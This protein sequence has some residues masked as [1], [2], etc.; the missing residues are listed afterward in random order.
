MQLPAT[1]HAPNAV[2]DA[3]AMQATLGSSRA[4]FFFSFV[5]HILPSTVPFSLIRTLPALRKP[6]SLFFGY[7]AAP[8]TGGGL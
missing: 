6:K 4:L 3:A 7:S 5:L 1:R 2:A 8:K